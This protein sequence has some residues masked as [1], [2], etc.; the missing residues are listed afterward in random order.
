MKKATL[1]FW[2]FLAIYPSTGMVYVGPF[3]T[4]TTCGSARA[5]VLKTKNILTTVCSQQQ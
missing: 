1:L 3:Q 5:D 2:F 4:Q